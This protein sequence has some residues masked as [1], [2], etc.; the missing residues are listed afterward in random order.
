M[1]SRTAP[2]GLTRI[3]IDCGH[4]QA[5]TTNGM[6]S[7]MPL[8]SQ[9]HTHTNANTSTRSSLLPVHVAK[10]QATDAEREMLLSGDANKDHEKHPRVVLLDRTTRISLLCCAVA[11]TL[12]TITIVVLLGLIFDRVNSTVADVDKSVSIANTARS[13]LTNVNSI[14]NSTARV[15]NTIDRL[16]GMTFNAAMFTTPYLQKM[17]NVTHDTIN[18][19]HRL[20]ERPTISIGGAGR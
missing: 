14:L 16:G 2:N 12:L 5:A 11:C 19:V 10:E 8:G 17:L 4:P 20:V 15:A 7:S 6:F 13:A 9:L 18:D 1:Q 3:Q